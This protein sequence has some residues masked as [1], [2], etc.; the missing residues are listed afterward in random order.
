MP[1]H[2]PVG[3]KLATIGWSF[4][5]DEKMERDPIVRSS[6]K[7]PPTCTTPFWLTATPLPPVVL[8]G[9]V[10]VPLVTHWNWPVVVE[11]RLR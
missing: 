6:L 1:K 9:P 4:P 11:R 5:V 7:L 8:S 3:R 2:A 10:D